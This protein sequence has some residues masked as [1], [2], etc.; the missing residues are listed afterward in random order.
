MER[1][2]EEIERR[3]GRA[4]ERKQLGVEV[5]CMNNFHWSVCTLI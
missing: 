2:K 4:E 5:Q 1:R 3:V